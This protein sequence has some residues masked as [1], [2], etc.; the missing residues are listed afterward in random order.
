MKL[1]IVISILGFWALIRTIRG[2]EKANDNVFMD[3]SFKNLP[4]FL[5]YPIVFICELA[6]AII[7]P[8]LIFLAIYLHWFC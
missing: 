2:M 8:S 5:F 6:K 4:D 7:L 3:Y 1:I